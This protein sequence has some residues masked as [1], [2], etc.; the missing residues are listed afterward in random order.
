MTVQNL[1]GLYAAVFS[2]CYFPLTYPVAVNTEIALPSSL[3]F[4]YIARLGATSDKCKN[5][6]FIHIV[7]G[8]GCKAA[9]IIKKAMLTIQI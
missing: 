8:D 4:A 9:K 6:Q 3:L 5:L 7:N 2:N 1:V